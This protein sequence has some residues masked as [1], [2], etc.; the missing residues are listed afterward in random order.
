MNHT[1]FTSLTRR[2]Q[3]LALVVTLVLALALGLLL[4]WT[5]R[6]NSEDPNPQAPSLGVWGEEVLPRQPW[7]DLPGTP[8]SPEAVVKAFFDALSYGGWAPH[9]GTVGRGDELPYHMAY[10]YLSQAEQRQVAYPEFLKAFRGITVLELL[11]LFAVPESDT[12]ER[13]QVYV[14]LKTLEE[15]PIAPEARSFFEFSGPEVKDGYLYYMA[16]VDVLREGG[17]WQIERIELIPEDFISAGGGHR[18]WTHSPEFYGEVLAK[19]QLEGDNGGE[20][21]KIQ[22]IETIQRGLIKVTLSSIKGQVRVWFARP[23]AGALLPLK[24]AVEHN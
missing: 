5:L 1:Y 19:G 14:E 15:V 23:L 9:F 20:E 22:S 8:D 13:A 6:G 2:K 18:V 12:G 16:L 24:V 4:G 7:E 11:N 10:G 21:P 17:S 3:P